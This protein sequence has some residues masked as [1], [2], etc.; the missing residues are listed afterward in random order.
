MI[1]ETRKFTHIELL[2]NE[3]TIQRELWGEVGG[4]REEGRQVLE[5][6]PKLL[7]ILREPAADAKRSLEVEGS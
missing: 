4:S 7:R 6:P 5:V 1:H 3:E 2:T